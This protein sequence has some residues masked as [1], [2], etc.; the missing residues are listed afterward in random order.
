MRFRFIGVVVL[1]LI[2]VSPALANH[3]QKKLEAQSLAKTAGV[4]VD[5]QDARIP[6]AFILVEG[7][8]FRRELRSDGLG[9]FTTELPIGSYRL[10]IRHPTFKTRKIKLKVTRPSPQIVKVSLQVK[11]AQASGGKCRKDSLCL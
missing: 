1:G 8:S 7:K 10:T 3:L 5:W 6:D 9:E 2:I 11:T 4:I